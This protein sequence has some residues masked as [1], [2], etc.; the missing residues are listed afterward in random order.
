M[1]R[2]LVYV[3]KL[4]MHA[5]EHIPNQTEFDRMIALHHFDNAVELLLKC[6]ATE[7]DIDLKQ[8]LNINFPVLWNAVNQKTSL[9]KRTEMFQL[10]DLRND[11]QHWG[12]SSFSLDVINRFDIYVLDFIKDVFIQVFGLNFEELYMSC[13]VEDKTLAELL[14]TAEAAFEKQDY[15]TCMR[16]ADAA[17]S[18]ALSRK[19][20]EFRLW[21]VPTQIGFE[22]GLA[23][24]V[25]IM[26]LGIDYL[27]FRRHQQFGTGAFWDAQ[28]KRVR[29][30]LTIGEVSKGK[31]S[32]PDPKLFSRENAFFDLNFAL[33]CILHWHL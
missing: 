14:S 9:P 15:V 33:E 6:V 21:N 32:K 30:S 25:E 31:E 3:K 13:L 19:K 11:V 12:V 24:I 18:E 4:Y 22:T 10:H 7:Y 23:D 26:I 28:E 27:K 17:L 2:R 5:H 20:E 29:Y 8:P 16:Y 1:K